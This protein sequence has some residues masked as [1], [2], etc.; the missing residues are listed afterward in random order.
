MRRFS[1]T[2]KPLQKKYKSALCIAYILTAI[3]CLLLPQFIGTYYKG[4]LS[5]ICIYVILSVGFNIAFGFCGVMTFASGALFGVGAYVSAMLVTAAEMPLAVSMLCGTIAAGI[6][7][8]TISLSAYKVSGTYLTLVSYGLLEIFQR[9]IIEAYDYTG[10]TSGYHVAKWTMFGANVSRN[11][12]FYILF[13]VAVLALILQ[14][15]VYKSQWGRD[16]IAIKDNEIAAT[17]VG[18]C[19]QR[20]RTVGFLISSLVTGFAGA[21]YASYAGFISPETFSFNTS[22]MI[23]LMVLVGGKGTL[24]GP[25]IGAALIYTVPL[26]LNDYPDIKQLSYGLML[27]VLMQVM[28][29]GICGIIKS[30]CKEIDNNEVV[31]N[32]ETAGELDFSKYNVPVDPDSDDVVL[33]VTGLTKQYGGLTACNSLDMEI[34]RGTIHALIGPNGAG[35]T[36]TI[37]NLTGVEF[38]TSGT[39]YFDG[40]LITGMKTWDIAKL[41]ISRTYQHVR[42]MPTLSVLDNIVMGAR[43]AQHYS[44]F[45]ALFQTKKKHKIDKENYL[46]AMECLELIGLGDKAD[47]KPDNLSSGQQ[48]LLELCRAL[49]VK[50]KLLVLDE[51][52]AGLT[53][54]ETEQFAHIMKKIRETGISML[55]VEHHMSLIMD[56]SDYITVIDHGTK[57]AEGLPAEIAANPIVRKSYLGE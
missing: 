51:P 38:P 53:E 11:A 46:E 32:R 2:E 34:K 6:V 48:K 54:T 19:P 29:M 27:I 3:L 23:L 42:L 1:P 26:L 25:I 7:G 35:K 15:N 4:I 50:P 36:T 52:C 24:S 44:L 16:F 30:R 9:I 43:M 49:V 47:E 45:D 22:V 12:K 20:L 13:V 5:L 14:R 8:F 31:Q 21:L 28:P 41:G 40:K 55:L 17:G 37:N 33:K 56:V 39:A 10:G 18:I 57:I